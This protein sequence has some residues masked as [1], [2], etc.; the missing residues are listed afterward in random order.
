MKSSL[1]LMMTGLAMSALS[2]SCNVQTP[3]KNSGSTVS[4]GFSITGSGQNA[5][6]Q[7]NVQKFLSLFIPSAMALTPPPL[8]DASGADIILNEAWIVVKNIEFHTH[9]HDDNS[10]DQQTPSSNDPLNQLG[11]QIHGNDQDTQDRNPHMKRPH[12]INLLSDQPE[13][14]NNTQIPDQGVR[15]LKM[16]L[17]QSDNIPQDAPEGLRGN[18]IFLSGSLNGLPFSFSSPDRGEFRIKG[19]RSVQPEQNRNMLAVIKIAHL[20]KQIDFSA[21]T[22]ARDISPTN[23]IP[24]VGACPNIAPQAVDLYTCIRNGLEVHGHFGKDNGDNDLDHHDDCVD[25]T[26]ESVEQPN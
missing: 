24:A 5:V 15:R 7:T 6:A 17:H 25:D 26:Q 16:H 23:K 9:E 8:V 19:P 10:Q 2:S 11:G 1:K 3:T 12:F 14:M 21:M 4:T 20:F 13:I 18:S 22:D